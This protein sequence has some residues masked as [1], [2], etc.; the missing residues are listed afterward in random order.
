M[1]TVGKT[2]QTKWLSH[3]A[4]TFWTL[5]KEQTI[6]R[7]NS[8][9]RS[10]DHLP[11]SIDQ[12]APHD[13]NDTTSPKVMVSW[14]VILLHIWEALKSNLACGLAILTKVLTPMCFSLRQRPGWC[15][16]LEHHSF[17][18][19]A[20]QF[21]TQKSYYRRGDRSV[22]IATGYGLDGQDLN[23][24]R[25]KIF[26]LSTKSR[27]A[28]GPTHPPIQWALGDNSSRGKAAGVWSWPLTTI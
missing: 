6:N 3:Y 7:H 18:P 12:S 10:H 23:P 24:S 16:K 1:L 4:S 17:Y 26:L 9:H 2:R 8:I 20:S 28:L 25:G 27:L 14:L 13:Q 19:C 22:G 11:K 5:C 21:T 15:L